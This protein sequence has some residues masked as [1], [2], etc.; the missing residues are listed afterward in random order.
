MPQLGVS[1]RSFGVEAVDCS[2]CFCC[3]GK[4][5]ACVP[6]C[7]GLHVREHCRSW[8][9]SLAPRCPRG[10]LL[11]SFKLPVPA[12]APDTSSRWSQAVSFTPARR[13]SGDVHTNALH[14]RGVTK[15]KQEGM[16]PVL[17]TA[18][19]Q[20]RWLYL[21]HRRPVFP[22]T[23]N[24]PKPQLSAQAMPPGLPDSQKHSVT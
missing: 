10:A 6:P 22:A 12:S 1:P 24:L 4:L 5:W 11:V 3:K 20:A 13:S 8:A 18:V 15:G 16:C 14:S 9:P 7:L 2:T 17:L 23:S 21:P 19:C